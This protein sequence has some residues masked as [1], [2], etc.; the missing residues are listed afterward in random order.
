MKKLVS[1]LLL[2]VPLLVVGQEKEMSICWRD[3]LNG[4]VRMMGKYVV[5]GS[6]VDTLCEVEDGMLNR[7]VCFDSL[8]RCVEDYLYFSSDDYSLSR[9]WY[10]EN[11]RDTLL[12]NSD[13]DGLTSMSRTQYDENGNELNYKRYNIQLSEDSLTHCVLEME[14]KYELEDGK[15]MESSELSYG[16]LCERKK[17]E[18]DK[19]GKLMFEYN[20]GSDN[21]LSGKKVYEYD[22]QGR[23]TCELL[24]YYGQE[25]DL[26]EKIVYEYDERG[27]LI[28]KL[29]SNF[30]DDDW[31]NFPTTYQY[32]SL[33][34]VIGKLYY[35]TQASFHYCSLCFDSVRY[36]Y[37]EDGRLNE[38]FTR[39]WVFDSWEENYD[40]C[41]STDEKV[42]LIYDEKG[43]LRKETRTCISEHCWDELLASWENEIVY[44]EKGLE[45]EE[46]QWY[47]GVMVGRKRYFYDEKDNLIRFEKANFKHPEFSMLI[48]RKIEYY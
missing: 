46:L 7:K 33:N 5:E 35:H 47:D 39:Y 29:Q 3:T 19:Q 37:N 9:I 36:S 13:E 20:Y 23:L 44:N 18:Y 27:N 48:V 40:K 41:C 8:G 15:V 31:R 24:Y 34:R 2:F 28:K 4:R 6:Y 16:K 38:M 45:T 11:G 42:A 22:D 1:L 10:D 43:V 14:Q 12:I 21:N 26:R 17:N 32:D 25:N 30:F